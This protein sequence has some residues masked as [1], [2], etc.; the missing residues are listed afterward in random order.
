MQEQTNSTNQ[1]KQKKAVVS[2]V[3]DD[4][5]VSIA[6]LFCTTLHLLTTLF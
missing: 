6:D 5:F 2:M 3:I 4:C 1:S